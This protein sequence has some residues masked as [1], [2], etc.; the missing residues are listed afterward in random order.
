MF[1]AW[2]WLRTTF[3]ALLFCGLFYLLVSISEGEASGRATWAVVLQWALLLSM[4]AYLALRVLGYLRGRQG[5]RIVT[6][7]EAEAALIRE[8]AERQ[9]G[10]APTPVRIRRHSYPADRSREGSLDYSWV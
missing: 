6:V 7:T 5:D 2:F 9:L 8:T 10:G 3:V 4:L 1:C